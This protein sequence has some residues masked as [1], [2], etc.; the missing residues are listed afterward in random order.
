MLLCSDTGLNLGTLTNC[1]AGGSVNGTAL[2]DSNL[3]SLTQGTS[4]TGSA[5]G[6]T[7]AK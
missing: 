1:V 7:L 6:T 5:N 4:S 3:A 2:N